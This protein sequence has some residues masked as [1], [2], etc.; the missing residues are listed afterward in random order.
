MEDRLAALEARLQQLEDERE[1]TRLITSY[2]PLV[3][4]GS[5]DEVAALWTENGVYDVGERY[6]GNRAEIHDMVLS[7]D[8]QGLIGMGC[9][10]FL[11][12][13]HVTVEGDTARAVC[14]SILL[15]HH[16]ERYLPVRV[17]ANHWELER[18]PD[19]WRTTRRRTRGLN[20]SAEAPQLLAAGITGEGTP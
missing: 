3:D 13:V 7:D 8:H 10:H 4:S 15:V 12:P 5:A 14:H 19:G 6:M 17:G 11:G 20:G 1:I 2:G 9:C 16:K 18:T